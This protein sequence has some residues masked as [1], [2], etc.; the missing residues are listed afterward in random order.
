MA[1]AETVDQ[2]SEQAHV[3]TQISHQQAQDQPT[4][5]RGDVSIVDKSV[6]H[7][8][9]CGGCWVTGISAAALAFLGLVY[10]Y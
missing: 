6:D 7:P 5:H 4:H 10:C 9:V 8:T 3:Q 2:I 1:L